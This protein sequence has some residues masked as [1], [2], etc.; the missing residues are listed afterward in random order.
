MCGLVFHRRK[1]VIQP[2]LE[3]VLEP[4]YCELTDLS[5]DDAYSDDE[6]AAIAE[7]M[8]QMH[9]LR[10]FLSRPGPHPVTSTSMVPTLHEPCAVIILAPDHSE[11]TAAQHIRS[12][13]S[14]KDAYNGDD[15]GD[16]IIASIA[17]MHAL[18]DTVLS[19]Q[20]T[21]RGGLADMHSRAGRRLQR[22]SVDL[23]GDV[24][25]DALLP[26]AERGHVVQNDSQARALHASAVAATDAF[27]TRGSQ[28]DVLVARRTRVVMRPAAH[29]KLESKI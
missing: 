28:D 1:M 10:L 6:D 14:G 20:P 19:E 26:T 22:S 3:T 16:A 11:M 7:S 23:P 25:N 5:G 2:S 17:R 9:V 8:A 24:E 29:P 15:D 27:A 12:V 13:S 21:A 18:L 4:D